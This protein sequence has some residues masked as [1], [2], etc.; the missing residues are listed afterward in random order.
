M[1]YSIITIAILMLLGGCD[2]PTVENKVKNTPH[3]VKQTYLPPPPKK[4]IKLKE[5]D[6][7]NFD[8]A[9]MYPK[10]KKKNEKIEI[11][12]QMASTTSNTMDKE[13][14]IAMITQEK[15]EK[16]AAMFGSEAASIKR[17]KML[18]ATR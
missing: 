12:E 2:Q 18:K 1:K 4:K 16:Y 17:C 10:D 9:Y 5:V 6:D 14:C 7:T 8:T 11:A 3:V 13:E 15:F